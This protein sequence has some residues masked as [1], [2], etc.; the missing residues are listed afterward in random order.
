MKK[1]DTVPTIAL[2]IG[3]LLSAVATYVS[4]TLE[5]KRAKESFLFN[6]EQV[7]IAL[8]ERLRAYELV[9]RGAAGFYEQSEEVT[10]KEWASYTTK[11]RRDGFITEIQGIGF[12]QYLTPSEVTAF[13]AKVRATGFPA[14]HVHPTTPR[15]Q[16][17]SIL[18][19]EPFDER[20]QRAFGYDMYSEV[21]R[22]EA[23]H[24][25]AITGAAALSG[26]VELLQEGEIVQQAGTLMYVPVYRS[27]VTDD[28]DA[29]Y[30]G[31]L[32]G[33]AYSPFRM[34]DLIDDIIRGWEQDDGAS[35]HLQIYDGTSSD[36]AKLL[37]Q[38]AVENHP[39]PHHLS[40]NQHF[41]F[42][43]REWLLAF[44]HKHELKAIGIQRPLLFAVLGILLSIAIAAYLQV[45]TRLR[46]RAEKMAAQLTAELNR[47]QLEMEDLEA[48]W[49]YALQ[50]SKAGVWD[51]NITTG[52][53][54]L[55]KG[56]YELLGHQPNPNEREYSTWSDRIYK[57]DHDQ[58]KQTLASII[59]H[60]QPGDDHFEN[61]YRM[62]NGK[63]DIVWILDRG[64]VVERDDNGRPARIIGTVEDITEEKRQLKQLRNAAATDK[65]TGLPNRLYLHHKLPRLI[66]EVVDK[67][68]FI[69]LFFIDLDQFKFVN[70]EYGHDYGDA[71]LIELAARFK[72]VLRN[73]DV[74]C[75]WGG[76]EFIAV[77]KSNEFIH[78]ETVAKR[79]IEAAS[80]PMTMH[81]VVLQAGA[82]IGIVIY[83]GHVPMVPEELIRR[84]DKLMYKA[85]ASQRGTFLVEKIDV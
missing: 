16:Y 57:D 2:L 52:D 33:W 17:S 67:E 49:R 19:L 41:E 11:L 58:L 71:M 13:E 80:Q 73:N 7:Q 40:A 15:E 56:W 9:L 45:A 51:W 79:L 6:I 12:A 60:S 25:A 84:A 18:Y 78:I 53:V 28:S 77:I 30:Y 4:Y 63:G 82:T 64:R 27:E 24:R 65:L 14:F 42:A 31:A 23:M 3:I 66:S 72:Q 81:D 35:I 69:A 39:L 29:G 55:S 26:R 61:E 68:E 70:D 1:L 75:R 20:N 62:Y 76:D 10:R 38:S 36:P 59:A 47:K 83:Y 50:A 48:R 21:T 74:L 46:V 8:S 37:Y 44:H 85:K 5:L 43:S 32:L 54:Y 34:T 22:R